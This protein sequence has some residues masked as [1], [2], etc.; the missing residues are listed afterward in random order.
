MLISSM[1]MYDLSEYRETTDAWWSG[2]AKF[3]IE[4]GAKDVPM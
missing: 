2:I 4:E 1:P 3:M